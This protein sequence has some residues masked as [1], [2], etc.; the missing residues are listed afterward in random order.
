MSFHNH[1]ID[2]V[3]FLTKEMERRLPKIDGVEWRVHIDRNCYKLGHTVS[4]VARFDTAG[5]DLAKSMPEIGA[6]IHQIVS[7]GQVELELE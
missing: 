5:D 3:E 2:K 4:V 1:D 6:K 7:N